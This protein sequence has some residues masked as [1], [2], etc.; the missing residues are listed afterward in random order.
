MGCARGRAARSRTG[1]DPAT[2]TAR[3]SDRARR[4]DR[5]RAV[6]QAV[7]PSAIHSRKTRAGSALFHERAHPVA[8][9]GAEAG[10]SEPVRRLGGGGR[11]RRRP[12]HSRGDRQRQHRGWVASC[13]VA[14]TRSGSHPDRRDAARAGAGSRVARRRACREPVRARASAPPFL[15]H[16]QRG[17]RG[18]ACRL[19]ARLLPGVRLVARGRRSRRRPP[20]A[21]LLVLLER[22]GTSQLRLYLLRRAGR[23]VRHRRTE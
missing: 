5:S 8:G 22:L 4:G 14:Q 3:A 20:H 15:A 12:P 7:A 1:R 10:A 9:P 11:R 17:A 16:R 21:S 2:T 18:R 19:G 6:T 13:R 23:G